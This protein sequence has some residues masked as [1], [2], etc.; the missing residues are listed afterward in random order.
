MNK[1]GGIIG[2]IMLVVML[3]L[4]V[5]VFA[6]ITFAVL[7]Y[8]VQQT[9]KGDDWCI[10]KGY[11]GYVESKGVDILGCLDADGNIKYIRKENGGE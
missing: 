2:S 1:Q 11:L 5:G 8:N 9:Q 10:E 4:L 3:F 6:L 7:E